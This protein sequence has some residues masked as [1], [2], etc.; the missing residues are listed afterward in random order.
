MLKSLRDNK[1]WIAACGKIFHFFRM[2]TLKY[3]SN[4][5]PIANSQLLIVSAKADLEFYL[6][7]PQKQ[8]IEI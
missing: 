2:Q 7:S 3:S 5:Q 4:S 1:G 8:N 6:N